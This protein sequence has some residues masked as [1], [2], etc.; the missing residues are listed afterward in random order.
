M[1]ALKSALGTGNAFD[2]GCRQGGVVH[3][4]ASAAPFEAVG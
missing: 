3:P 1:L 4:P 2:T